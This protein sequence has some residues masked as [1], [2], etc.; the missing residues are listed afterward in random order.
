VEFVVGQPAR[1]A[2]GIF[3]LEALTWRRAIWASTGIIGPFFL[4]CGKRSLLDGTIP[5]QPNELD[6]RLGSEQD[7]VGWG[8]LGPLLP[9]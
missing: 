4:S 7:G 8:R 1:G 6:Q 5:H 3:A 2:S 9:Q